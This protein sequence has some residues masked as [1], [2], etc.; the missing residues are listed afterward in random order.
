[1]PLTQHSGGPAPAAPAEMA[2]NGRH[3]YLWIEFSMD[4]RDPI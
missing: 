1:M 4:D 2:A 3:I